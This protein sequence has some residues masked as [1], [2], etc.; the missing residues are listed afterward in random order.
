MSLDARSKAEII[1]SLRVSQ[2]QVGL[3]TIQRDELLSAL[4]RII[5]EVSG[6]EPEECDQDCTPKSCP[7]KQASDAIAKSEGRS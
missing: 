2:S 4:K 7:W 3:L 1:E 6:D 5:A